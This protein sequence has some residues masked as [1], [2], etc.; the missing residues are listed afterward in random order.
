VPVLFKE[1]KGEGRMNLLITETDYFIIYSLGIF[2]GVFLT[3]L[4]FYLRQKIKRR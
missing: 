2:S 4:G 3:L 1:S